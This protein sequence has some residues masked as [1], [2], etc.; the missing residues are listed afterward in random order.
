MSP[1]VASHN[2]T[3][4]GMFLD[5]ILP[6]GVLGWSCGLRT[7]NF[8]QPLLGN[9]S[10]YNAPFKPPPHASN[11]LVVLVPSRVGS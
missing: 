7:T 2:V 4:L 10:K 5:D 3:R 6:C 9:I 11:E 8:S 1:E